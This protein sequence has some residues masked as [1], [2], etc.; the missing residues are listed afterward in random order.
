LGKFEIGAY[1]TLFAIAI[2]LITAGSKLIET[3]LYG[4]ITLLVVGI[5]LITI[6]AF[7]IDREAKQAG[8]KAAEKAV[9]KTLEKREKYG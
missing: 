7:L 6:W 9:E 5:G 1:G 4:G 2:S 3:D 8:E